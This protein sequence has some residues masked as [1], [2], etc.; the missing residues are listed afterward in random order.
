MRIYDDTPFISQLTGAIFQLFV[1]TGTT[2]PGANVLVS[3]SNIY[4]N[5]DWVEINIPL[6]N[7]TSGPA[8][9]PMRFPM[10]V[11]RYY[12]LVEVV[13]P[14]AHRAPHGQW[15]ITVNDSNVPGLN[16]TTIGDAPNIIRIDPSE[17]VYFVGNPLDFSLTLSGSIGT[18]MFTL[19]GTA[20][21]FI[22]ITAGM[23][24]MLKK[25][26]A[27]ANAYN[28]SPYR[29]RKSDK[30]QKSVKYRKTNRYRR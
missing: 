23:L 24:L 9:S 15:R 4:P 17:V 10:M 19:A 14:A 11:G 13:P 22:G 30:Y 29:Y 8:G 2:P 20:A 26:P 6:I 7:R 16:I 5:G 25:R 1:Y 12:Q 28:H 18:I 27:L 3:P 21:I